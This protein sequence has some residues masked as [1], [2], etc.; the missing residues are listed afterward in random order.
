[1]DEQAVTEIITDSPILLRIAGFLL[2]YIVRFVE[3]PFLLALMLAVVGV[4]TTI[5]STSDSVNHALA[6]GILL[7]IV[8][9]KRAFDPDINL[10]AGIG[11]IT[12][13]V[14]FW[15]MIYHLFW[16]LGY[17]VTKNESFKNGRKRISYL[18]WITISL[19]LLFLLGL[20]II[21]HKSAGDMVFFTI[22]NGLFLLVGIGSLYL[23]NFL[24][25]L[26]DA[27]ITQNTSPR[28]AGTSRS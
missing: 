26:A 8:G 1:M 24:R 2:R 13:C 6:I 3:I 10:Q 7:P 15:I 11:E 28:N 20:K 16:E 25:K 17:L 23:S 9:I 27:M 22:F 12:L 4:V 18:V 21:E 14:S 19:M 5:F